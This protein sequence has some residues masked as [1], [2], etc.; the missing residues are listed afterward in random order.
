MPRTATYM[1]HTQFRGGILN[2]ADREI[3]ELFTRTVMF[4]PS[5][6][7]KHGSLFPLKLHALENYFQ[8]QVEST[9]WRVANDSPSFL[10][11]FLSYRRPQTN[12]TLENVNVLPL[13]LMRFDLK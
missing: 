12:I 7:K 4:C 2:F 3:L 9:C 5:I 6:I 11:Q 1:N 8:Y 13:F 10:F